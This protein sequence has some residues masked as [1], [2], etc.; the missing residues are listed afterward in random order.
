MTLI[1]F[2]KTARYCSESE[3]LSDVNLKLLRALD[4]FDPDKG[5]AFT[6]LSQVVTNTLRTSVT[7]ARKRTKQHVEFDQAVATMLHTNGQSESRD[8]I[9]DLAHRIRSHVKTTVTD[10][11]EVGVQ[12]W[13]VDSFIEGAFELRRH[14]CADA[15]MAVYGLSHSRSRELHDLTLLECRRILYDDLPPRPPV[16]PAR[17]VGTHA[18]WMTRYAHLMDAAEFSK[19]FALTKGLS[20]FVVILVDPANRSRRQDRCPAINRRNLE[21]VLNGHPDAA[22]LFGSSLTR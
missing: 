21:F 19:F 13:Y 4:R 17:L 15:A 18:Q 2:Y 20:L 3:L 10:P 8:A 14:E 22:P 16:V 1:R 7:N 9:D 11:R 6:F 5:S 12:R